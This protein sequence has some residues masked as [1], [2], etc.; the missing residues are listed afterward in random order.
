MTKYTVIAK[1]AK[2]GAERTLGELK[3]ENQIDAKKQAVRAYFT[4]I[5]MIKE[6]LMVVRA[7]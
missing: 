3:A 1:E 2:T 6:H 5:N 4:E 7:R